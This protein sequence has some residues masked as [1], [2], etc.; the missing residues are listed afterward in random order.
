MGFPRPRLSARIIVLIVISVLTVAFFAAAMYMDVVTDW[1]AE[2][3]S[4][5][6]ASA[7]APRQPG[8]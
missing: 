1:Q 8:K 6:A 2:F 7:P 3:G 4:H 5:S